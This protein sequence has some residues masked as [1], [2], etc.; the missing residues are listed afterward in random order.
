M[1]RVAI[2]AMNEENEK[3]I[4]KYLEAHKNNEIDFLKFS[5]KEPFE[6]VKEAKESAN[7]SVVVFDA[8][9]G[10]NVTFSEIV[11]LLHE[12][13]IKPV[14]VII[15]SE[16]AVDLADAEMSASEVVAEIDPEAQPWELNFKTL[17]FSAET[18]FSNTP[19][20]ERG[21]IDALMEAI[22]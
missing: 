21:G 5:S 6:M 20:F 3:E 8:A 17:F 2:F 12:E 10:M 18:G 13:G 19:A 14:L 11:A 15:N 22:Q 7:R 9:E 1:D 4:M 16:Y